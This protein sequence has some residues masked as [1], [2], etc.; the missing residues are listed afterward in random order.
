M[1]FTPREVDSMSAWEF[2]ACCA[3]FQS[4]KGAAPT[5]ELPSD[6]KLRGMGI[7]GF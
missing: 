7:E 2:M 5:S 1:G 6:E 3:G 4:S